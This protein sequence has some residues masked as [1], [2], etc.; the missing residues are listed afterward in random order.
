MRMHLFPTLAAAL[1]TA[2]VLQ[3]CASAGADEAAVIAGSR[4]APSASTQ[5]STLAFGVSA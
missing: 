5:G 4:G 1:L 3:G 2:A